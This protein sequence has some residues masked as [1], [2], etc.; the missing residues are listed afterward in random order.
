MPNKK[1][2]ERKQERQR[3]H[4]ELKKMKRAKRIAR[5]EDNEN[6]QTIN[7]G[8]IGLIRTNFCNHSLAHNF[9]YRGSD[10][11]LMP[12]IKPILPSKIPIE[13]ANNW[14]KRFNKLF[15]KRHYG[16]FKDK[17][18]NKLCKLQVLI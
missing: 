2:K 14:T 4:Q 3:K 5:K 15:K 7:L 17:T 12:R 6:R 13:T 11:P 9:I 16:E 10:S 18:K 8:N 1:A